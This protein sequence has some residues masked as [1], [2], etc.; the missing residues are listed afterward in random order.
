MAEAAEDQHEE[1]GIAKHRGD[2]VAPGRREPDVVAEALTRVCVDAGIKIR[3]AVGQ[4]L[5]HEGQHQHAGA[6]DRPADQ[7][8]GRPGAARHVLRQ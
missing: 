4:G 8:G 6:T 2:P 1:A 5:E 3:P 7:R